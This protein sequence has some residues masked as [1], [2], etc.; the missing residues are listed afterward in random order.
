MP[1]F[2]CFG[3]YLSCVLLPSCI[4]SLLSVINFG[5]FSTTI[6]SNILFLSSPYLLIIPV[7]HFLI[8]PQILN[9]LLLPA[10]VFSL[11]FSIWHWYCHI[12]KLIDSLLVLSSLLMK[13][14]KEFFIS[15]I[16]FF[17]FYFQH[18]LLILSSFHLFVSITFLACCLLFLL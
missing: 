5:K 1:S 6:T 17:S 9:I 8:V 2:R 13:S 18:I 4:W 15:V 16:V 3:I 12:F 14:W 7:T 11:C 10:Y